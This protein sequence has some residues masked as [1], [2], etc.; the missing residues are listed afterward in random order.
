MSVGFGAQVCAFR[1]KNTY[2]NF[3]SINFNANEFSSTSQGQNKDNLDSTRS[4]STQFQIPPNRTTKMTTPKSPKSTT[5]P[6]SAT[7]ALIHISPKPTTTNSTS[8]T[9]PV[10]LIRQTTRPTPVPFQVSKKPLGENAT[11]STTLRAPT[12]TIRPTSTTPAPINVSMKSTTKYTTPRATSIPILP[13]ST[14]KSTTTSTSPRTTIR[15]STR[16]TVVTSQIPPKPITERTTTTM[17]P[18]TTTINSFWSEWSPTKQTT[19]SPVLTDEMLSIF[20]ISDDDNSDRKNSSQT[21]K[22]I[23][24]NGTT[25]NNWGD[26]NGGGI[27]DDNLLG[28]GERY[29]QK[30]IQLHCPYFPLILSKHSRSIFH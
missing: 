26:G 10:D 13:K 6:T 20:Q 15:S 9:T 16:P 30:I 2:R 18:K 14:T 25:S 3:N 1:F 12:S 23:I 29:P 21:Q 22:E 4:T 7:P 24:K 19:E 27:G 11:T 5:R 8:P 17:T 28:L